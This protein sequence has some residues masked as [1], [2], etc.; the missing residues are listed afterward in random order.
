MALL[1]IRE[2]IFKISLQESSLF[3]HSAC[4]FLRQLGNKWI[5][6]DLPWWTYSKNSVWW[7]ISTKNT[8]SPVLTKDTQVITVCN[9]WQF[10]TQQSISMSH[11]YIKIFALRTAWTNMYITDRYRSRSVN[12][13]QIM[14]ERGASKPSK[15]GATP[16]ETLSGDRMERKNMWEGQIK[17]NAGGSAKICGEVLVRK[18]RYGSGGG[19]ASM[20]RP[21]KSL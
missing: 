18:L 10:H 8:Q 3:F 20:C 6:K 15:L 19:S 7:S 16:F 11:R 13:R 4:T 1:Y 9:Q 21:I 2:P 17:K 5:Q 14:I 12:S